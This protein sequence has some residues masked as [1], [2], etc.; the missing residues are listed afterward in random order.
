[1]TGRG[2]LRLYRPVIR[3]IGF[4]K[5]TCCETAGRKLSDINFMSVVV[6]TPLFKRGFLACGGIRLYKHNTGF[7][8]FSD[9]GCLGF[10]G[11]D[12]FLSVKVVFNQ[13]IL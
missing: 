8:A 2:S 1:M 13:D 7:V 3:I 10:G 5:H 4:D 12:G 11:I 9:R 6:R